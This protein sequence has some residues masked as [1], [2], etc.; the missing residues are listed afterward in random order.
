VVTGCQGPS[1]AIIERF[2]TQEIYHEG[3]R[4]GQAQIQRVL[5][6]KAIIRIGSRDEPLCT[7][8]EK[9][10]TDAPVVKLPGQDRQQPTAN[11]HPPICLDRAEI[12]SSFEDLHQLMKQI[13]IHC[14]QEG[15]KPAGFLV[16]SIKPDSLFAKMGLR[17]GD[18][19]MGM[20]DKPVASVQQAMDFYKTFMDGRDIAL[21]IKRRGRPQTLRFEVQ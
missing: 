17:N 20:N 19:I 8:F 9:N 4:V 14:Y 3:D 21:Q 12:V 7:E 18:I 13:R 6:N 11:T 2:R 16:S 1:V 5:R 10:A 15:E